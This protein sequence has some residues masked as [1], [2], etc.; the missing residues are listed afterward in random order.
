MAIFS[1]RLWWV[2]AAVLLASTNTQARNVTHEDIRDAMMSLVH[3]FRISEDKLE[4][5]EYREKALGEQLKKM[6][7]GLEKKHR[8]LESMKGTISRLDDR[9]YNVENIFLQKEEREKETQKKT[10]EALDEIKK[11]LQTLTAVVT[12]NLKPA[13]PAELDNSLNPSGDPLSSRLDATD[14]KL[15]SIKKEVEALKNSLSKD[16][17]RNM[18]LDVAIEMNPFER[19]ISEAEKLLNKYDMKLNELNGNSTKVQTDFVPLSEVALA[20]EAWHSKMTEVMER[21]EKSI[22]KIQKLLSDAESMWK[23]LPRLADLQRSSNYTLEGLR[24]LQANLTGNQDKAVTK[25]NLKLREMGDRLVATNEDIQQSLTQGNTMSERAYNDIQTSYESLRSEVQA[26]S[27]NEHVMQQTAD[28]VLATKKRLEYGVQQITLIMIQSSQLNKTINDRLNSLESQI[29]TNQTYALSN[30]TAKIESEMSQV[31]RQIGIVYQQLTAS[32]TALD[33][34]T[35]QTARYVNG[36]TTTLDNMKKNVGSITARML[37]VDDNLNYLLGRLSLVT[38]EFGQIKTGLGDALEKAKTS[39]HDV[40][41]KLE[42]REGNRGMRRDNTP[43][44]NSSSS[45]QSALLCRHHP[46]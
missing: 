1:A 31:W 21:Q 17:L 16:A 18:C 35:E 3:M 10:N 44:T 46:V 33:G 26:F 23:D 30:L 45:A 38:Q 27:K 28:S 8:N 42:G 9:L 13:P 41:T 5:H 39:F 14:A 24:D 11:S 2:V 40:Q 12:T 4:R 20:D 37:E 22:N 15:D 7:L 19:H 6:I 36:S 29:V 34:L 32:R 25:I 43:W